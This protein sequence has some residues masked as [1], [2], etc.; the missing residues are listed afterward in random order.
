MH[1]TDRFMV[2]YERTPPA[3]DVEIRA[4]TVNAADGGVSPFALLSSGGGVGAI[5]PDIGV[6][7]GAGTVN[8]VVVWQTTNNDVRGRLVTVSP[9]PGTPAPI[10]GNTE[11]FIGDEKGVISRMPTV[12]PHGGSAGTLLVVWERDA[13]GAVNLCGRAVNTLS[14]APLSP[15]TTL[16]PSGG[17][18]ERDPAC[19]TPDGT[20]FLVVYE[21]SG[22]PGIACKPV[23]LGRTGTLTVGAE[24][25]LAVATPPVFPPGSV[26]AATDPAVDWADLRY[27]VTY[28]AQTHRPA[29]GVDPARTSYSVVL[30][31]I[32]PGA[33]FLDDLS[34]SVES[35]TITTDTL[36]GPNGDSLSNPAIC[37]I[38]T[39]NP[40]SQSDQGLLVWRRSLT[41]STGP[42]PPNRTVTHG[43]G[44]H[45]VEAVGVGGTLRTLA[46]ACGNA[47]T[48]SV[49]GAAIVSSPRF[50][51]RLTGMPPGTAVTL[52]NLNAPLPLLPCGA[53]QILPLRWCSPSSVAA[54][55]RRSPC[56]SRATLRW[57]T[58]PSRPRRCA[59]AVWRR[60]GPGRSRRR[61]WMRAEP[62]SSV[63]G[64]SKRSRR[65]WCSRCVMGRTWPVCKANTPRPW[66]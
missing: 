27:L 16:T 23:A 65:C 28:L 44:A 34:T 62:S 7:V 29:F 12:S 15:I 39:G 14:L 20:N 21:H 41:V 3:A 24:S 8:A 47:G 53:C 31:E 63:A 54:A 49:S 38:H 58:A 51:F 48:T 46:A 26:A 55:A 19:A 36:M 60:S 33:C 40:S 17:P 61:W 57:P 11:V 66:S 6:H 18:N 9:L 37:A 2:V 30:Q 52:F 13:Q 59:C 22:L 4:R 56:R 10:P 32:G 5:N 35:G 64:D 42:L 25:T 50:A 45:R 1:T 43:V